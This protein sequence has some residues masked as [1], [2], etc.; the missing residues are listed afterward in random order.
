MTPK[1]ETT[2]SGIASAIAVACL[3]KHVRAGG[4][5]EFPAIRIMWLIR[6]GNS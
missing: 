6:L 3:V 2:I 1:K 4:T 5:V